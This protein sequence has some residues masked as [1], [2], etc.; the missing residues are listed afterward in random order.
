ME[1]KPGNSGLAPVKKSVGYGVGINQPQQV[2]PRFVHG[3]DALV[4]HVTE[5][6]VEGR[7]VQV[8]DSVFVQQALDHAAGNLRNLVCN[9]N[10][11]GR[12]GCA[13]SD[14]AAGGSAA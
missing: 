4:Q 12:G 10:V 13:A 8:A 9:V 11:P 5:R 2:F 7:A 14:R 3:L 1:R 6:K